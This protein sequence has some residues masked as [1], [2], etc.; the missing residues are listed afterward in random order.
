MVVSDFHVF[1]RDVLQHVDAVQKDHPGLPVFLLGHSMV[2][3]P[4]R[5]PWVQPSPASPWVGMEGGRPLHTLRMGLP[6]SSCS[7]DKLGSVSRRRPQRR[8]APPV[9]SRQ[10]PGSPLLPLFG[11]GAPQFAVRETQ[12]FLPVSESRGSQ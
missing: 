11:V 4:R 1:V 9:P 5:G 10:G 6:G 3:R 7:G 8:A 12:C 2:S